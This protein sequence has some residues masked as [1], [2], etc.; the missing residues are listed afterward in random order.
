[1]GFEAEENECFFERLSRPA[2]K[3]NKHGLVQHAR[4]F[5]GHGRNFNSINRRRIPSLVENLVRLGHC[6]APDGRME[7]AL[8]T[9]RISVAAARARDS[10]GDWVSP[11]L[12]PPL[13]MEFS[14]RPHHSA[15]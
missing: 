1:M 14:C 2:E 11:Y 10:T 12:Q 13:R 5:A 4:W 3:G 15:K 9:P 8:E 7:Q 6:L